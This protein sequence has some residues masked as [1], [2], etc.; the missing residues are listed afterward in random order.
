MISKGLATLH[1]LETV[2]GLADLYTLGEILI[3]DGLNREISQEWEKDQ[4]PR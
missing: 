3:V 1:E 2:Y 4:Q